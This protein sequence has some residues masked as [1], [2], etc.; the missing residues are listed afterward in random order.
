VKIIPTLACAALAL[1]SVRAGAQGSITGT[2]YDSLS[3]RAPLANATVV[4][5]D[6]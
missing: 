1:I 2:V 4:L 5:V 6:S 3:T